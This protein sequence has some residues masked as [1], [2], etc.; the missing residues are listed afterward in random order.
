MVQEGAGG[1]NRRFT[2]FFTENQLV[3]YQRGV[4]AYRYRDTPCCKSPIDLAIYLRLLHEAKPR[5]LIEIGSK[6]GGS[7]LLFRDFARAL[8]LKMEVVS[9]DLRRPGVSFDAVTFVEGDV[10]DLQDVFNRHD[11]DARPRPWLVVEDSAHTAD[12]CLAALG[13]FAERLV[14]GEWLVVEDGVLA[15]LGM[16]D[17]YDGG[18]NRAIATFFAACPDAFEIGT[19]YCD[20]FGSNA[21]YN[22]NG[23]LRRTASSYERRQAGP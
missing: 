9:I 12:A 2:T 20:M 13:F 1:M 19:E 21:T 8:D 4:M 7:A 17:R 22:P 10:R 11:L 18:P 14:T 16:S 15:D 6:D 5:T 3:A 23:Y